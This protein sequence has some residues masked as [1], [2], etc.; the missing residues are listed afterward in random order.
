MSFF[1][2]LISPV[3]QTKES[4][5]KVGDLGSPLGWEGL[6]EKRMATYSSI[7]AW[8]ISWI[9]KPDRPQSMR[10]QRVGR[11]LKDFDFS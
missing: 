6:L 10:F 7:L 3:T 11:G 4:G 5:C 9:E 2:S 1:F 8:R